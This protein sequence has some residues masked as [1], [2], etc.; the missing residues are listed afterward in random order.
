M[1]AQGNFLARLCVVLYWPIPHRGGGN[2]RAG[3]LIL[4]EMIYLVRC[5]GYSI[6]AVDVLYDM[7]VVRRN[8]Q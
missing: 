1:R 4:C 2:A 3:K 7:P 6:G 5:L 8:S